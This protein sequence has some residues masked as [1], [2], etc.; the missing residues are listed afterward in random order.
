MLGTMFTVG[1]TITG[2]L[3]ACG[4]SIITSTAVKAVLAGTE[5][6]KFGK[7]CAGIGEIGL[8]LAVEKVIMDSIEG[9][10]DGIKEAA[11]AVFKRKDSSKEDEVL[12]AEVY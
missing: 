12:E 7:V 3:G 6:T 1:K 4:G 2:V 8:S 9:T 10:F 11:E 5:L